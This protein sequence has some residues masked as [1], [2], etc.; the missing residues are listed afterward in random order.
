MKFYNNFIRFFLYAGASSG[1]RG[2]HLVVGLILPLFYNDDDLIKTWYLYLSLG[3]L[4][5]YIFDVGFSR[6]AFREAF[7]KDLSEANLC[8]H[9]WAC[10]AVTILVILFGVVFGGGVII[11]ALIYGLLESIAN[12][13]YNYYRGIGKEKLSFLIKYSQS[14]SCFVFFMALFLYEQPEYI[15]IFSLLSYLLT[16]FIILFVCDFRFSINYGLNRYRFS[17][18]LNDSVWWARSTSIPLI[19]GVLFSDKIVIE[20]SH[21]LVLLQSLFVINS[22]LDGVFS[23]E[24]YSRYRSNVSAVP[25][26]I[27]W[28][29]ALFIVMFC[30]VVIGLFV[31]EMDFLY[32]FLCS[33][34]CY[35]VSISLI[36][37]KKLFFYRETGKVFFS[38]FIGVILIF[39]ISLY[40]VLYKIEVWSFLVG[41][42]VSSSFSVFFIIF[43]RGRR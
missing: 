12:S 19:I 14:I 34:Y 21:T 26:L 4:F 24:L 29:F 13:F 5:Y 6:I 7:S 40:G 3:P 31:F 18:F 25:I 32:V 35:L 9:F 2:L 42:I 27:F 38:S 30:C 23:R 43:F 39:I 28:A 15:Y 37:S 11:F 1:N 16:F 36:L 22:A 33:L 20:L 17:V 10:L 41:L 8:F